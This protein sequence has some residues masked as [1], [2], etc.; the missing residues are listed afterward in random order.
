MRPEAWRRLA[1]PCGLVLAAVALQ[2]DALSPVFAETS[3]R[4]AG[5]GAGSLDKLL[6]GGLLASTPELA[7]AF[8]AAVIV[9]LVVGARAH[10]RRTGAILLGVVVAFAASVWVNVALTDRVRYQAVPMLP[11]AVIAGLAWHR[12]KAAIPLAAAALA[13]S[14]WTLAAHPTLEQTAWRRVR[15][16]KWPEN[17]VV[18]VPARR[19]GPK[20]AVIAEFPEYAL[21]RGAQVVPHPPTGPGEGCYVW[22]GTACA[23][24]VAGEDV[25]KMPF[26]EGDPI[27]PE[28]VEYAAHVDGSAVASMRAAV[29][30]RNDEFHRV[31]TDRPVVG[32]SPCR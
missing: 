20:G 13:W 23:S 6:H 10:G 16:A 12:W 21:P 26:F 2:V 22:L 25:S 8:L 7:W 9:G 15:E 27:R 5:E 31:V 4:R 18:H 30:W 28:C 3:L 17:A 19:L 24:F 32:L 11:L 14:T 1:G 29:P